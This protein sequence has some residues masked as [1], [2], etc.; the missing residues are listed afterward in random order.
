MD[1]CF[2][3]QPQVMEREQLRHRRGKTPLN[4]DRHVRLV[5]QLGLH[6]HPLRNLVNLAMKDAWASLLLGT[7]YELIPHG[8]LG[9]DH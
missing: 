4:V 6:W 9:S 5:G 3:V 8:G 2:F 1:P 7:R